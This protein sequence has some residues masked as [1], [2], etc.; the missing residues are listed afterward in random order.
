MKN[1]IFTILIAMAT[2]TMSAQRKKDIVIKKTEESITFVVDENRPAPE[3]HLNMDSGKEFAVRNIPVHY[4]WDEDLDE[5][6]SEKPAIQNV[7][8]VG[9]YTHISS[10]ETPLSIGVDSKN[11]TTEE[12]ADK[13][14]GKKKENIIIACN[15]ADAQIYRTND[16]VMF[17]MLMK[18]YAEHRPIVLSPDDVWLCISQG[19]AHHVNKNAKALRYMFVSHEGKEDLLAELKYPLLKENENAIHKKAALIDWPSVFNGL[20]DKMK[21]K[22]KDDIVDNMC[23]DFSTT[24][25]DSRIASQTTLLNA[26]KEY[27]SYDLYHIA[28]C[29]IPYVT[30]TGTPED[31]QKVLDK[32]RKLEQYNLKWWTKKLCPVLEQFVKA[33][34]GNPDHHFWKCM[35]TRIELDEI[36]SISCQPG[37]PGPTEFDGWFLT[38]FPYDNMG[39]TPNKVTMQHKMRSSFLS[40]DFMYIYINEYKNVTV[41]PMNFQAG[42]IGIEENTETFELRPR[43]GWLVNTDWHRKKR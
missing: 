7:S 23:A 20:V 27:F 5:S 36:R 35:M 8:E 24:T 34:Q 17:D 29:G 42:F 11:V 31:W 15:F 28:A 33:S 13:K 41:T 4:D 18:A 1:I 14:S 30:L 21:K 3:G 40:A 43:I 12:K 16:N 9:Q 37:A 10:N 38:L 26:M 19:F 6:Q 22:T 39:R 25:V 2:L 32:A